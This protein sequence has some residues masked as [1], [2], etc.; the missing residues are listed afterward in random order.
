MN[1]FLVVL[2]KE[3]KDIFRD[4]KTI[5]F[6]IILPIILFPVM[7]KIMGYGVTKT[8]QIAE[9]EINIVLEGDK[10]SSI[11][12]ILQSQSN[13][14]IRDI[15]NPKTALKEGTIQLIINIPKDFDQI[16]T[17]G[18]KANLEV[19]YDDSSNNSAMAVSLFENLTSGLKDKIV[20]ERL[21]EKGIDTDILEP[22]SI[23]VKSGIVA[24]GKEAMN[25]IARSL[26]G[27]MPSLIIV[28]MFAPILGI[29]ADLGAGEK[30][31]NTFEPLLSTPCDRN[32]LIFGKTAAISVVST[33]TMIASLISMYIGLQSFMKTMA[34]SAGGHIEN[35]S[36]AFDLSP[37]SLLVMIVLLLILLL[38]ICAIQISIS[39]FAR[40]SKEAGT[41]LSGVIT[42]IM[43]ISYIPMLMDA[44]SISSFM[45]HVPIANS[46]SLMK[47][48]MVGITNYNHIGIVLFWN[49]I[50]LI[51]AFLATKWMFS[52]EEVVFRS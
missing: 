38:A 43:L 19:L 41:Y 33:L 27:M 20:G 31:R 12:N 17:S 9:E 10:A 22:F 13:I 39:I 42:P 52:R 24:D 8:M 6:T 11:Y 51:L 45:F 26:G 49:I 29:A 36:F 40:S 4:K 3:L 1:S 21:K 48:L 30:E 2:K 5:L 35:T 15:E 34:T 44:K 47:E 28:F 18:K 7:Y 46:V 14:K 37:Q 16:V 50:Y 25:P 32:S 23:D